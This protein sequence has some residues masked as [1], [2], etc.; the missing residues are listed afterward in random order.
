MI[1]STFIKTEFQRLIRRW[2]SLLG[3]L[4]FI[5][6]FLV[7][8]QAYQLDPSVQLPKEQHNA[9]FAF[10]SAQGWGPYTFLPLIFPLIMV[11]F[12]GDT[13]AWDLKTGYSNLVLM[14]V[15]RRKYIVGKL[16]SASVLTFLVI[17]LCEFLM[18]GYSL[19]QFPVFSPKHIVPGLTPEY[20]SDLATSYPFLYVGLII[21][22][23]ALMG[24]AFTVLAI[25]LSLMVRNIVAILVIPWVLYIGLS[26]IVQIMGIG[27][28][29]PMRLGV[30]YLVEGTIFHPL[31]IP[32]FWAVFWLISL[33]LIF[34]IYNQRFKGSVK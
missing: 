2:Q 4:L 17:V 20:A 26:F 13:L 15:G 1:L 11:L 28:L 10:Y 22:N 19:T 14:R 9:F 34:C 33:I 5:G 27:G 25:L 3:I 16:I 32:L 24:M 7:A 31:E 29:A 12:A 30:L 8:L 21:L 23:T 6:F 18:F